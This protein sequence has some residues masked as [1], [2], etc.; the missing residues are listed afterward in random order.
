MCRS[1]Y[2]IIFFQVDMFRTVFFSLLFIGYPLLGYASELPLMEQQYAAQDGWL[3]PFD[4]DF[5]G[6]TWAAGGKATIGGA[7]TVPSSA[8]K[9]DNYLFETRPV[10]DRRY[11]QR[12]HFRFE[13]K[14]QTLTNDSGSLLD[15]VYSNDALFFYRV[16]DQKLYV[17]M[18]WGMRAFSSASGLDLYG[19]WYMGTGLRVGNK[20]GMHYQALSAVQ[21]PQRGLEQTFYID[22]LVGYKSFL[23]LGY[24]Q[25]HLSWN[26]ATNNSDLSGYLFGVYFKF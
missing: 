23:M 25:Q 2:S 6:F 24:K 3:P 15:T 11:V 26:D 19:N 9:Y 18:G 10:S 8:N 13:Y 20:F 4:Y 17:D 5:G 16:L 14:K 22:Y 21:G 7:Q 12:F 1:C